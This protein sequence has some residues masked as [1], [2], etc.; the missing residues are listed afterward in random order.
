MFDIESNQV[1]DI[2][3][4]KALVKSSANLLS[5]NL[6]D[7]PVA[8]SKEYKICVLENCPEIGRID[9]VIINPHIREGFKVDS[10]EFRSS[11]LS[12]SSIRCL[13]RSTRNTRGGLLKSRR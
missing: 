9:D 8:K 4:I 12:S 7:N 10:C 3:L 1:E 11:R 6:R 13:T 2:D 5:I